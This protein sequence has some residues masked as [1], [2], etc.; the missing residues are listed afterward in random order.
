MGIAANNSL[1]SGRPAPDR[2]EVSG[3]SHGQDNESDTY[4]GTELGPCIPSR[5]CDTRMVINKAPDGSPYTRGSQEAITY[6]NTDDQTVRRDLKLRGIANT[7]AKTNTYILQLRD[8][9]AYYNEIGGHCLRRRSFHTSSR[10]AVKGSS[11][12]SSP[13]KTDDFNQC[14]TK[15]T[16]MPKPVKEA[17]VRLDKPVKSSLDKLIKQQRENPLSSPRLSVDS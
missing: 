4:K 9:T 11:L 5:I 15:D 12:K 10:N 14:R 16:T 8:L 7:N 3:C 2:I 1:D 17:K 6:I 13:R